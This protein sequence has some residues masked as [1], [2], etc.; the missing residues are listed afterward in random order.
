MLAQNQSRTAMRA[1]AVEKFRVIQTHARRVWVARRLLGR[2]EKLCN[3]Y[4]QLEGRQVKSGHSGG[5]R[6]VPIAAIQ[7]SE[8]RAGDFD[9]QFR[10]LQ[11]HSAERWISIA[12]ARM[13]DIG[14]PPVELVQIGD[15][16][17]VRDGHHRISVAKAFGQIDIDAQVL[18]WEVADARRPAASPPSTTPLAPAPL[19]AYASRL[20]RAIRDGLHKVG[21]LRPAGGVLAE[22]G[23][24]CVEHQPLM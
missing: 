1:E 20:A 7:G 22:T 24:H 9:T 10:P 13:A 4:A 6:T 16:Y 11:G 12:I 18:V 5:I 3:L 23:G 15:A 19:A 17:F 14:L 8:G 2:M 21:G